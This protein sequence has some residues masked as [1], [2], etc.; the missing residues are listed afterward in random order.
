[1]IVGTDAGIPLCFY[2]RYAD[3]LS[4]LQDAGYTSREII[5]GATK[6]AAY[7]CGLKDVTGELRSG[8]DADLVAFP[9]NPLQDL[10][11]LSQPVFVMARGRRHTLTPIAPLGDVTEKR[12]V[13]LKLLRDGASMRKAQA[14]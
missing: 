6:G 7:E 10:S 4:V 3:G 11:V 8:L 9:G 13:Y 5:H 1:M 2:E 14:A 12:E